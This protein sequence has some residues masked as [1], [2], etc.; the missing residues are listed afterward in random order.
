MSDPQ[1]QPP[2]DSNYREPNV[3]QPQYGQPPNSQPGASPYSTPVV[4]APLSEADD[5]QWASLAHL[6]GILSFLPSLIIW[7]VF[8]DRGRFTNTEAKEALNFQITLLIAYV[9]IT[10]VSTF[11]ALVTFGIGGLLAGL[12]WI[13]W[14]AGVIFSIMGFVQAKDGKNYR[15]P[16]ALRLIK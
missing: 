7:L 1:A 10:V 13:V 5:R 6:G 11:L 4:A 2:G 8:K 15:Y 9:A 12:G 16:F 3:G 14:L